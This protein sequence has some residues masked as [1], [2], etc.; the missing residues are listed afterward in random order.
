M[1]A[2]VRGGESKGWWWEDNRLQ[3]YGNPHVCAREC[4]SVCVRPPVIPPIYITRN[5]V[6]MVPW[7]GVG[8]LGRTYRSYL[9]L[10]YY[11]YV[12]VRV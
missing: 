5:T 12:Y 11:Y 9:V 7:V 8:G 1:R 4:V 3:H 10:H 6:R 2:G